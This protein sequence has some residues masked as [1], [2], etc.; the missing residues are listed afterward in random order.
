MKSSSVIIVIC[1]LLEHILCKNITSVTDPLQ[2]V[3]AKFNLYQVNIVQVLVLDWA[4]HMRE[5]VVKGQTNLTLKS[6]KEGERT[7]VNSFMS[8]VDI[9]VS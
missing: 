9:E 3:M 8:T 4:L 1:I 6:L 2:R 5:R 7:L